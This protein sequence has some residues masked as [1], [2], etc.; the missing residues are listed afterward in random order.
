MPEL[1]EVETYKRDLLKHFKGKVLEHA[2]LGRERSSNVSCQDFNK[3]LSGKR[4]LDIRRFG[5]MLSFDFE[6]GISM[7]VHLMISGRYIISNE[8]RLPDRST[9]VA[10]WFEGNESLLI[11]YLFLGFCRLY[12]TSELDECDEVKKLGIDPTSSDFN[13]EY[14][15]HIFDSKKGNIKSLLLDQG[16]L[17]GIGNIYADEILFQAGISPY[18]K[19]NSLSKAEKSKLYEAIVYQLQLGIEMRG[20]TIQSYADIYGNPGSFQDN[21]KVHSK[22]DADC[23][24]CGHKLVRAKV[25][26]RGTYYCPSCQK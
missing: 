5:K 17:S 23:V 12:K 6:G 2:Y 19:I 11:R 9:Q 24:N 14:V 1:P 10:F 7:L 8:R 16:F 18:R 13:L 26:G 3:E 25:G 21:I 4:L 22:K 15:D 20:A